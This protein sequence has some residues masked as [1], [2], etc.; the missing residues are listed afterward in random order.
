MHC[1]LQYNY[2]WIPLSQ[3]C[4]YDDG[5]NVDYEDNFCIFSRKGAK[6]V[7]SIL[8]QFCRIVVPR[9]FPVTPTYPP[10]SHTLLNYL[11]TYC[12]LHGCDKI[13]S[14]ALQGTYFSAHRIQNMMYCAPM[15]HG[16]VNCTLCFIFMT[17]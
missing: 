10:T 15:K 16:G 5:D 14:S 8:P 6:C 1:T 4:R 13:L 12:T 7:A 11:A 17:A 9:R 3:S 2:T